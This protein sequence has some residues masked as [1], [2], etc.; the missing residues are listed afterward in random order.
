MTDSV[1][2]NRFI[3]AAGSRTDRSRADLLAHRPFTGR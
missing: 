3:L 2:L 1:T